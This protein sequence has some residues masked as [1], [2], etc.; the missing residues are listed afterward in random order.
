MDF[1]KINERD[2]YKKQYPMDI[3]EKNIKR[4]NKK[5]VLNT[6]KLTAQFCIQYLLNN[7]NIESGS[8]DSYIWDEA[9]ILE[10]QLHIT[11]EE[12]KEA[13]AKQK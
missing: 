4:L 1:E 2:L 6:Q 7:N 11:D 9:Y 12:W 13:N 10:R 3:L 8:E 5:R